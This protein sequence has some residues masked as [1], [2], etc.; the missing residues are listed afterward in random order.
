MHV[1]ALI[2]HGHFAMIS[3]AE[4]DVSKDSDQC[5]EPLTAALEAEVQPRFQLPAVIALPIQGEAMMARQVNGKR[6]SA[7]LRDGTKLCAQFQTGGCTGGEDCEAGRHRCAVLV[8]VGAVWQ[9][10]RW[11]SP[12][13]GL[14]VKCW[15]DAPPSPEKAGTRPKVCCSQAEDQKNNR[16][17][18]PQAEADA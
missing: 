9:G 10:L 14:Q 12:G 11:H 2:M 1:T 3:T 7:T 8:H 16:S 13:H 18:T 6:L 5:I 4:A 17:W 15:V